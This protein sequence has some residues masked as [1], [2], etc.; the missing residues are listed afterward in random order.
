MVNA[1]ASQ[2]AL[3]VAAVQLADQEKSVKMIRFWN[4]Y[5]NV[6]VAKAWNN[7][8][9]M[10]AN[11]KRLRNLHRKALSMMKNR[12]TARSFLTW[13]QFWAARKRQRLLTARI[14]SRLL[15][16]LLHKGFQRWCHHH[17]RMQIA[18]D[19]K[20][21]Y[22]QLQSLKRQHQEDIINKAVRRISNRRLA[23]AYNTW[24]AQYDA[25]KVQ[26]VQIRRTMARWTK[27]TLLKTFQ[28]LAIHAEERV[29]VRQLLLK[30]LGRVDNYAAY[31]YVCCCCFY[32][33]TFNI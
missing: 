24:W 25:A 1:F 30:V 7:W 11:A 14:I 15:N 2:I 5:N 33:I 19:A 32:F 29:R 21:L 6:Q 22:A 26:R 28:A 17:L 18:G 31:R 3:A 10:W 12:F 8:Y 16:N 13:E 9:A 20:D 4:R 23:S 27:R